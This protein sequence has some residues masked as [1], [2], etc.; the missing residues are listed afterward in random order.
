MP[1]NEP[2]AGSKLRKSTPPETRC[3]TFASSDDLLDDGWRDH[4]L[5]RVVP[6]IARSIQSRWF[7]SLAVVICT[8]LQFSTLARADTRGERLISLG[9]QLF[10]DANLSFNRSASCATCH[11]PGNGY[12]DSRANASSAPSTSAAVSTGADGYSLGDRNTPSLTYV[13]M[14]PDFHIR[15]DGTFL[16]GFFRDGRA[17]TLALQSEQP[18]LD[19]LEMAM[20]DHSAIAERLRENGRYLE[21]LRR[22]L[23]P[24]SVAD[25]SSLVAGARQAIA[26]FERSKEFFAFDSK[27]DRYLAG[28]YQM[29][30]DEA[31]GREL[32]FSDL[33]NCR[34]CH[35]A[36]PDQI[37]SRETFSN[38]EYHNIGTP[39]N[40]RARQANGLSSTFVDQGLAENPQAGTQETGKFRVP[41]LRNVAVTAPY[42]HNGVF[43]QLETAVV[44][45]GRHLASSS[46]AEI[47]PE[48]GQPVADGEH[49][50][51]VFTSLTKQAFPIIRYRTRDLTRLLPGTARSMRRMEKVTGRSDDM[52]ILRGVNVFPTQIEEALMKTSGLAPHFQ[53]ELSRPNRMD[54]LRVLCECADAM[55]T[56]DARD[57]AARMLGAQIKQSVG[58][59]VE[60]TVVDVGGVAR[61][62]GKA[63]RIVDSRPK[64]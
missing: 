18:M 41:S 53:I 63:V 60:I 59:S 57:D 14:T 17:A 47:N 45:Y 42:M 10:F 5:C 29:T 51:L 58:I 34:N 38:F 36:H 33:T 30:R 39:V 9:Q 26:A 56:Q 28:Q 43:A 3:R 50:E 48:T 12:T 21:E 19:P 64:D 54:Q 13:A 6:A 16:G 31:I 22:L 35:L 20:P 7:L 55:M 23:G 2:A 46:A 37:S 1:A 11:N 32:F 25:D 62:E 44:F 15:P 61:S 4:E 40:Q 52:I 8:M 27:Y 49:G 24:A